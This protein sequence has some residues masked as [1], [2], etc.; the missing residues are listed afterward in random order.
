MVRI[1]VAPRG[2][3][4]QGLYPKGPLGKKADWREARERASALQSGRP[5]GRMSYAATAPRTALAPE[6]AFFDAT[7]QGD[8]PRQARPVAADRPEG[9]GDPRG[10]SPRL[11]CTARSPPLKR[12]PARCGGF[13]KAESSG[14]L[15]RRV[16]VTLNPDPA[17]GEAFDR[18]VA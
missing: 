18:A 8:A 14:G 11:Q 9:R 2:A 4:P 17:G 3:C 6:P 16:S 1:A 10:Q 7:R 5:A 15:V 13:T 12:R